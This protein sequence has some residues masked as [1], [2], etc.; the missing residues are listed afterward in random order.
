MQCQI[1]GAGE[2]LFDRNKANAILARYRC[3]YER[4]A[5]DDLKPEC[6]GASRNFKPNRSCWA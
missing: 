3:R 5:A 6:T 4:I 1:I 2:K